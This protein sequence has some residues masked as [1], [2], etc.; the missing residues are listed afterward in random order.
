VHSLGLTAGTINEDNITVSPV[1]TGASNEYFSYYRMKQGSKPDAA[2][3][4]TILMQR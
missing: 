3:M 4:A 2:R 1:D